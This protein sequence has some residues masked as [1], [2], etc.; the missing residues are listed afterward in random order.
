MKFTPLYALHTALGAQ[1]TEFAGWALPVLYS[2]V[3]EENAAVRERAGLFD[4][5]HL[6]R[7]EV[8]GEEAATRLERLLMLRVSAIFPGKCEYGLMCNE[9]GGLLDDVI[10]Y[11]LEE[12]SFLLVV[13]AGPTAA[14]LRWI[15]HYAEGAGVQVRERT[16]EQFI[17]AL[18]GP[19]AQSILQKTC[20][21]DLSTLRRMRWT[22]ATVADFP[23]IISRTGYT[24]EDGFEIYGRAED[25]ARVWNVLL[26]VGRPGGLL[27][28][29]LA[30]RDLC[31]LEAGN[32]LLGQ[33]LDASSSPLEAGLEWAVHHDNEFAMGRGAL[34]LERIRRSRGE[35]ARRWYGFTL[36]GNNLPRHRQSIWLENRQ[37]GE[38][39]SGNYSF[40][41]GRPIGAGYIEAGE[42]AAGRA[43]EVEI[44]GKRLPA[45]ISKM[46]FI[47]RGKTR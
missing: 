32:R 42:L 29:G 22:P 26:E 17:L 30:A 12:T 39:T 24:G 16:R 38:V 5:S 46:P 35:A 34:I 20:S 1:M 41:L 28:C 25:A 27:P 36:E 7:I 13:N 6:G 15:R 11:R 45:R 44:R 3:K 43:I 37:V 2:S 40:I 31:R 4:V 14:D 18:Q 47:E 21:T 10:V 19:A 23:V 9:A 8:S 33:D